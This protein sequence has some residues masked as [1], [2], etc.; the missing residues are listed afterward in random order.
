MN[1]SDVVMILAVLFAPFG[2]VYAQSK[3]EQRR[4]TRKQKL[5]IFKTLMTTRAATLSP[6]HVQALNM[7]DL[8][9]SDSN[10]AEAAVKQVWKEY[11]DHICS[12][13]QGA[14]ATEAANALWAEKKK[15]T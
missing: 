10:A 15:T 12:F 6:N 4:A 8:E 11:F 5:S 2:A 7:I 1:I 3:I 14:D 9:F 13:P